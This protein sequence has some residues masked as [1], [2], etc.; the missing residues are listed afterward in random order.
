MG[1]GEGVTIGYCFPYY[2]LEI[3]VG[4]QGDGQGKSRDR[5]IPGSP[6]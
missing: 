5:R 2:F 3:F 6:H 1:G 4:G